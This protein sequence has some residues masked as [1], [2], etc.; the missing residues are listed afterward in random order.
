MS[1]D[2]KILIFLLVVWSAVGAYYFT[3]SGGEGGKDSTILPVRHDRRFAED[4]GAFVAEVRLD[5]LTGKRPPYGKIKKDIFRPLKVFVPSKPPPPPSE[6]VYEKPVP[7]PPV[8]PT[9]PTKLE[10]FT[11][12]VR[13]VGFMAKDWD[14][15]VFLSRGEEIFLVRVGDVLEGRIRV[16]DITEAQL[17][18]LD[19]KTGE[20]SVIDISSDE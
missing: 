11:S 2:K 8:P 20:I 6:A 1:R 15:T 10:A 19:D 3:S 18:F 17:T 14:K 9:P 13:F 12:S 7:K 4:G 16:A 5:L